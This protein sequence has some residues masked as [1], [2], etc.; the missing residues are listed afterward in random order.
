MT[1][2]APAHSGDREGT[3][4]RVREWPHESCWPGQATQRCRA[5]VRRRRGAL[6]HHE[7]PALPRP[8]PSLAQAG[9]DGARP[10]AGRDRP[11]HR[12][13]HGHLV[14]ALRRRGRPRRARR[15]QP[16]HAARGQEAPR[17]PRIHRRRRNEAAVRRCLVRRRHDELRPA[18][19]RRRHGR[20]RRVRARDEARRAPADLRV[21]PPDERAVPPR[22]HR[23]PHA[24]AAARR[25]R[26]QLEPGE[27]RL[28]RRV[29]PELARAA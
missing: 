27:L 8:G 28:P 21:Q 10:Q 25:A 19:R 20:A 24:G 23:V 5:H 15:L 9:A 22:L 2:R 17:R 7:R 29:D 6:R 1:P 16:R 3:R 18:Q 13:R 11:R 26:R 12:R 14:G 4:A